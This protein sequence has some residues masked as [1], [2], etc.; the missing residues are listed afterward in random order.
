MQR[1]GGGLGCLGCLF[2]FVIGMSILAVTAIVMLVIFLIAYA[3]YSVVLWLTT[4]Q[5]RLFG[6]PPISRWSNAYEHGFYLLESRIGA[7]TNKSPTRIFVSV[8][9]LTMTPIIL[10]N[11]VLPFL[12]PV[13][14]GILYITGL[15]ITFATTNTLTQPYDWFDIDNTLMQ[16]LGIGD[17]KQD[18]SFDEL[19][20]FDTDE[21]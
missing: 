21:W 4:P 19:L 13:I 1:E 17:P 9:T 8:A 6:A 11:L 3:I 12:S 2:F 16:E 15:S 14:W 7:S 10:L 18:Y 5:P 20:P